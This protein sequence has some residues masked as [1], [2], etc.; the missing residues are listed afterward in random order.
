[1]SKTISRQ[2][3]VVTKEVKVGDEASLGLVVVMDGGQAAFGDNVS[4]TRLIAGRNA[5]ITFGDE[6]DVG[7]YEYIGEQNLSNGDYFTVSEEKS[8]SPNA[9]LISI[10][11]ALD[12]LI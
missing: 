7:S 5:S 1:M 9:F 8:I 3:Q 11:K 6:C 2:R 10:N 12:N 4:I